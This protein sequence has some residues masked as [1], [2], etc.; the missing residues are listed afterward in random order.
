MENNTFKPW[1]WEFEQQKQVEAFENGGE[2]KDVKTSKEENVLPTGSYHK[3]KH[4][5]FGIDVTKKG[6][7]VITVD[8][9]NVSTLEEIQEQADSV[10]QHA[11]TE[12]W[13]VIFCKETT[14]FIEQRRKEWEQTKD[15][16]LEL[17]VGK[18]ITKELLFNTKDRD[19][20][21][22]QLEEKM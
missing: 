4:E 7:P 2:I 15:K 9:D 17:E 20:I 10:V 21:I 19:G 1:W 16:N 11:E 22:E 12:K 14:D 6:I 18:R 5:D 8:N 13:E 3:D